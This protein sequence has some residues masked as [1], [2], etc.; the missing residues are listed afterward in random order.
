MKRG[1]EIKITDVSNNY[2]ITLGTVDNKKPKSVYIHISSWGLPID[3]SDS[4]NYRRV[5]NN[6]CKV[7]KQGLYNTID[8]GFYIKDRTIVDLDM[9]ESGIKYNKRSY[10]CTE[11]TLYQENEYPI[12][13]EPLY[14]YSHTLIK[15]V[16]QVLDTNE[17]FD[18]HK[19]KN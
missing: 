2:T 6:L 1:K 7:I 12:N 17:D 5:I 13:V 14:E 18:F 11:V 9:R 16:I 15:K 3:Y 8:E 10:M 19:T 4:E